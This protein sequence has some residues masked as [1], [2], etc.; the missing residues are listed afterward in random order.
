MSDTIQRRNEAAPAPMDQSDQVYSPITGIWEVD[1]IIISYLSLDTFLALECGGERGVMAIG[2]IL[3]GGKS[4]VCSMKVLLLLRQTLERRVGEFSFETLDEQ[5]TSD[6]LPI[7]IDEHEWFN[8][9]AKPYVE[10]LECCISLS[11]HQ[12]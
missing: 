2:L 8:R 10:A 3:G 6:G 12:F 7:P 5:P 4:R 11:A 9:N 1:C